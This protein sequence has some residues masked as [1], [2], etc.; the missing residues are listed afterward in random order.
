MRFSDIERIRRLV[1][2]K[3]VALVGSGPGV[4][5]N[6]P[7]LIDDHDVIV[8]V[9]NYRLTKETG[10]R[11]DIHYSFYGSS[12]KKTAEELKQDGVKLCMCKCPDAKFMD[13]E[14][15]RI[16]NKPHGVDFR[17]IY[18][19][20]KGWWFCPYYVPTLEEFVASFDLLEQHIPSTGFSA[21]LAILQ[22]DPSRL[23]LTGFDFFAS[24]VHN[25]NEPWRPGNPDDPIGHAPEL[26]RAWLAKHRDRVSL[27][28]ALTKIMGG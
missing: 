26:E 3:S 19:Q 2:G 7:G 28:S 21:I 9:N 6:P 11:T 16:N 4:L 17:Y 8:R 25:V 12:I 23:Y 24:R 1:A 27:D 18:Q 13:S 10:F 22:C 15:H 14:W 5:D 20:R